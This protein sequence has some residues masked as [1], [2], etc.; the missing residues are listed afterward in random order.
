M[1]RPKSEF[2]K[3][4]GKAW[5]IFQ[6]IVNIV[7]DLGGSDEDLARLLSDKE[8]IRRIGEIIVEKSEAKQQMEYFAPI[9]D[10][11]VPPRHQVTL[12]KYRRLA[13]EWGVPVTTAV[14]YRVKAGFTLKHHAPKAGPCFQ[15]FSYLQSWNFPD[16]PTKDC[17]VFW[18]P[19]LVP[20]STNKTR[21]E[22][23]HLLGEIRTQLELPA[24]H[25]ADLG[26]VALD[27]GLI[28]AHVKAT[29]E[30]MQLDYKWIRTDTCNAYG[31]RLYLGISTR[32]ASAA[33]SGTSMRGGSAISASSPWGWRYSEARALG[34]SATSHLDPRSLGSLG[35]HIS[36]CSFG[37]LLF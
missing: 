20:G 11:E 10:S 34:A 36:V 14:C 22:Q 32:A 23:L 29:N 2:L 17:L 33:T 35:E 25:L 21:S 5:E 3:S 16:E 9:K 24:H 26:K 6:V 1:A 4:L 7:L 28:L 30:L 31:Y 15:G 37:D 19:R 12:A 8:R 18:I 13:T 27:V